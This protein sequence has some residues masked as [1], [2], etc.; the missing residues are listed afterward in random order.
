MGL[1]IQTSFTTP[2]GIDI[3]QVYCRI[4][5]FHY[6][7]VSKIANIRHE[8]YVSREKRLDS[9]RPLYVP[10][11]SETYALS[12][13]TIPTIE[14]LYLMIRNVFTEIGLVVTDVF[15]DGQFTGPEQSTGENM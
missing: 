11:M 1:L 3:T 7:F 8:C 6:D 14:E 12:S 2:E 13:N 10:Y 15:E 4:V 5:S 9:Y